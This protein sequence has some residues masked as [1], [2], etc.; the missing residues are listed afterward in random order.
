MSITCG[1]FFFSA[2]LQVRGPTTIISKSPV[3]LAAQANQ[4]KLSDPGG[5]TFR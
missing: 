1:F 5:G 2:T 3:N 4:K